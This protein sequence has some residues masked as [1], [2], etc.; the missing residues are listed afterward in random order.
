MNLV[1]RRC[2]HGNGSTPS[3]KASTPDHGHAAL[4]GRRPRDVALG[5]RPPR[6]AIWSGRLALVSALAAAGPV[7]RAAALAAAGR[8]CALPHSCASGRAATA[9]PSA[10]S[11]RGDAPPSPSSRAT[12]QRRARDTAPARPPATPRLRRDDARA[13]R[14]AASIPWSLD[15]CSI[16]LAGAS[17]ILARMS[18]VWSR[19]SG[20]RAGP[21]R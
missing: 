20:C 9:R 14:R 7:D 21:R 1:T 11:R 12:S 13:H 5:A 15:R 19:C 8:P 10:P 16:W 4:L 2:R 18:P 17:L 6:R 3:L